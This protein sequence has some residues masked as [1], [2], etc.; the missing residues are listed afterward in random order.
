MN[1]TI[2][3]AQKARSGG[4]NKTQ[5]IVSSEIKKYGFELTKPPKIRIS[6]CPTY[7]MNIDNWIPTHNTLIE[8]TRCVKDAKLFKIIIQAKN[9]KKQF[10]NQQ[11]KVIITHQ[12]RRDTS[13]SNHLKQSPHIDEVLVIYNDEYPDNKVKTQRKKI[14]EKLKPFLNELALNKLK[15]DSTQINKTKHLSMEDDDR[16]I[17]YIDKV[18]KSLIESLGVDVKHFIT[19]GSLNEQENENQLSFF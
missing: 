7:S 18:S 9:F 8:I 3:R 19:T 13:F 12:P 15:S 16:Y 6:E 11:F 17:P 4:G 5:R 1:K 10:P 2:S 14:S